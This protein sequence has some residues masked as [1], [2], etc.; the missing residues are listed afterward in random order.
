MTRVVGAVLLRVP[1]KLVAR[2]GIPVDRL[3]LVTHLWVGI[4]QLLVAC[5]SRIGIRTGERAISLCMP[6]GPPTWCKQ[7]K[8]CTCGVHSDAVGLLR[9]A[10]VRCVVP[11]IPSVASSGAF[12]VV[13][14]SDG[15][16]ALLK[17]AERYI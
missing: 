7:K 14:E 13:V 10:F 12:R 11:S 4:P 9:R 16:E 8:W 15:V 5:V 3:V 1:L 2:R 6:V 17:I